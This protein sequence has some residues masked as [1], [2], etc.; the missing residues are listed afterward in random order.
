MLTKKEIISIIIISIILGFAISLM[1]STSI[2]LLATLSVFLAILINT[3]AKKV[4]SYYLDSEIEIKLWEIRKYGIAKHR[5]FKKPFPIGA[6]LPLIITTLTLGYLSW[7]AC[8]VFDVKA[9][10]YRAA[11][12]HGLYKFSEMTEWHIGLIAAAG[13]ISNLFFAVI[14][15]LLGYS[16]FASIN[17]YFAFFNIIPL[18]SLDGNKIFFGSLALWSFIASLTLI[19]LFCIL[20]VI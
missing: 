15:Y 13:V 6:V 5:Y 7:F 10:V 4:M 2:F 18:S 17:A 11:K 14:C 9:K 12:R 19:G 20:F 16:E 8:L 1:K 3:F